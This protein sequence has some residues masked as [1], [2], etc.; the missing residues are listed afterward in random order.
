MNDSSIIQ[1]VIPS[2]AGSCPPEMA[3]AAAPGGVMSSNTPPLSS[4]WIGAEDW[5]EWVTA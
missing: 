2:G 3:G 4:Q 1:D 5:F